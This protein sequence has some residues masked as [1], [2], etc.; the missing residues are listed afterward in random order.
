[1][2]HLLDINAINIDIPSNFHPSKLTIMRSVGVIGKVP[3]LCGWGSLINLWLLA[4]D[5]IILFDL[6]SVIVKIF[7][8]IVVV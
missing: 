3:L 8:N 5:L 6:I 4:T 2:L 7:G 1:V